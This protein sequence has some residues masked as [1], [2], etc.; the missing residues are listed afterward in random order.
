MTSTLPVELSCNAV[1]QL[2]VDSGKFALRTADNRWRA[3]I[4]ILT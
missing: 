2:A 1:S 4:E 3:F